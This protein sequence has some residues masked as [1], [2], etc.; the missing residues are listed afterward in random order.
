MREAIAR[1][2][3]AAAWLVLAA[4]AAAA[5]KAELFKC[6]DATG[7]TSIQSAPCAKGST[8]VWRRDAAP[9]AA[10]TPEQAAQAQA[11]RERD[12][13]SVRELSQE[14]ERTLKPAPPRAERPPEP[15]APIAG[16]EPADVPD[17]CGQAQE[18]AAQLRD[19][20]WLALSEDQV[21]RLYGWV[22]TQ[23]QPSGP[24]QPPPSSG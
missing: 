7:I 19:K 13:R 23:C 9:E 14:V 8:Q 10:P 5:G 2:M 16:T 1:G 15:A 6:V 21:R 22:A 18:F 17:R 11:R 4:P 20:E 24:D 3:W 12:E